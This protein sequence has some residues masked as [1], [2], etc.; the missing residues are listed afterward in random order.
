[1]QASP[2]PAGEKSGSLLMVFGIEFTMTSCLR[3]AGEVECTLLINTITLS[4][5]IGLTVEVY[6]SC[7]HQ[8]DWWIC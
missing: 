2:V 1:M 8:S 6:H 7:S 3:V 4:L 5:F